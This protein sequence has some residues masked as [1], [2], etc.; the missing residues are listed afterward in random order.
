M[1]N[2]GDNRTNEETPCNPQNTYERSKWAAEELVAKGIGNCNIAIFRPTNVVD[3]QRLGALT[4]PITK[5]I[6]S[7]KSFI[8]FHWN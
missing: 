6:D 2:D 1:E 3:E 4:L 5:T 8:G 7:A